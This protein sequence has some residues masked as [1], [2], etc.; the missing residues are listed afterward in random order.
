MGLVYLARQ[1]SLPR[2]VALKVLRS[3]DTA[4]S[5]DV[6]RFR[7]EAEAASALAHSG[8]AK[9]FEVREWRGDRF[10]VME[11][12]EGA[13][14]AEVIQQAAAESNGSVLRRAG[15]RD[16]LLRIMI[17]VC[18]AVAHAHAHGVIHRDLKPQN[19][20]VTNDDDVK[21]LDFGLAKLEGANHLTQTGDV[22]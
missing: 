13:T 11:H 3:A 5:H 6:D 18:D 1:Q 7:R 4:T 14:L 19:I 2:T 20:M 17:Q 12:V 9:V 22:V 16:R 10:I 8:I 21:V 15:Q